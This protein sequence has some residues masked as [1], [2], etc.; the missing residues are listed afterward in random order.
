MADRFTFFYQ[1]SDFSGGGTKSTAA[2]AWAAARDR[3]AKKFKDGKTGEVEIDV[4][5]QKITV[6][7]RTLQHEVGQQIRNAK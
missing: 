1:G 4:N 6:T 7:T 5:G 2:D 3:V